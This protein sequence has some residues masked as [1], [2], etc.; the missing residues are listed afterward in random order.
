MDRKTVIATIAELALEN[1]KRKRDARFEEKMR[2]IAALDK[3]LQ[4]W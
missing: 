4:H 2:L 3:R 1:A